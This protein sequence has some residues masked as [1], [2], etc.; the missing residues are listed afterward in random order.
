M[1]TSETDQL[2]QLLGQLRAEVHSA[3][4]ETKALKRELVVTKDHTDDLT[5][6]LLQS[7]AGQTPLPGIGLSAPAQSSNPIQVVLPGAVPL[8][9]P[10]RFTGDPKRH[11][12]FMKQC[13]LNFL[14][15]PG[16]FPNDQ[17]TVAYVLSYLSGSAA[18]WSVPLVTQDDLL[19]RDFQ[20]FQH[21]MEKLFARHTQDQALD[22]ELLSLRQENQYLLTYIATFSRLVV[23]TV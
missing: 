2:A 10:E 3:R 8:A 21:E 16:T 13:R 23:E 18:D 7:Q 22:N 17:S 15:R 9:P 4:Q 6:Q 19:L 20:R 1:E 5:R 11:A 12:V 14:C